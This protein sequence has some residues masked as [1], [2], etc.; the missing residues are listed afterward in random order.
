MRLEEC[1]QKLGGNYGEVLERLKKEERI[2]RMLK[3]VPAD[4]TMQQLRDALEQQA[5]EEAFRCAH[6]L[7]GVCANLGLG[8]LGTS[9]SALTE[10]LR[11]GVPKGNPSQLMA[12]VEEDYALTVAAIGQLEE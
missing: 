9:A 2:A 4:S 11:G 3:K 1:Y 10:C 7:K 5:Y 6:N 8:H 12:Q